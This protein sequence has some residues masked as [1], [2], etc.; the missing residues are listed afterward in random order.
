MNIHDILA[1][2]YLHNLFMYSFVSPDLI[3]DNTLSACPVISPALDIN[4]CYATKDHSHLD[5]TAHSISIK[6]SHIYLSFNYRLLQKILLF[7]AD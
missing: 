2:C 7:F 6:I 3:D 4:H 5:K 1:L